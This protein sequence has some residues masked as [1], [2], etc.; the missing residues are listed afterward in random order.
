MVMNYD[1]VN[2]YQLQPNL[3]SVGNVKFVAQYFGYS[4]AVKE[5]RRM[6]LIVSLWTNKNDMHFNFLSVGVERAHGL[7]AVDW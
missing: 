7:S 4:W 2:T 3:I 1:E 6:Y 5:W